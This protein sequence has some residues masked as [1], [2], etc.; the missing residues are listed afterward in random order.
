M[1]NLFLITALGL[2]NSSAWESRVTR[3]TL[4]DHHGTY[5]VDVYVDCVWSS[6][7]KNQID[8]AFKNLADYYNDLQDEDADKVEQI[9][10]WYES[11]ALIIGYWAHIFE[12][13][14]AFCDVVGYYLALD[15]KTDEI[16]D[17]N[18]FFKLQ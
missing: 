17:S 5:E 16:L 14:L 7:Q 2:G 10:I 1:V 4:E 11:A 18:T 8:R 15:V 13:D 9:I 12:E 6:A 3:V